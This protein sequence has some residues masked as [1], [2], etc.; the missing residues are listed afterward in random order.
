MSELVPIE[1]QLS[2]FSTVTCA[3]MRRSAAVFWL[4]GITLIWML[5]ECGLSLYAAAAAHSPAMLA[6][7]SD[8]LVE[9]LSAGVVLLQFLPQVSISERNAARAAGALLF[10]LALL[11]SVMAI[12]SL[13]LHLRP[14]TSRLG[15]GITLAALIVMPVLA[16]LKRREARRGTNAAL[17][18]DAV[19][20]AT[21]AYLAVIALAGVAINAL[22]HI[23]WFD[24][25]AAL[26]AI[27]LLLKEGRAAWHGKACGCC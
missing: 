7:G 3:P 21:C 12:G 9:L 16:K 19:Q 24:S 15:I 8:S 13:A 27:P 5:V 23:A 26:V 22:F 6:F 10:A 25:L 20:S 4:Q 18:A 17:A 1:I 14:E 2:K 11:V